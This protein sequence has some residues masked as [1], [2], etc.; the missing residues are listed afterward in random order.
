[1]VNLNALLEQGRA[2]HRTGQLAEAERIYREVLSHAPGEGPVLRDLAWALQKQAKHAAAAEAMQRAV[3]V[4][5]HD[6]LYWCELGTMLRS[7]GKVADAVERFQTSI[8]LNPSLFYSHFNLGNAYRQLEQ[9]Q[10]ARDCYVAAARLA[11]H[12]SDVQISL[13]A[14]QRSLGEFEQARISFQRAMA[15]APRLTEPYVNLGLIEAAL[16]NREEAV[17]WYRSAVENCPQSAPVHN[18]LGLGLRA[19]NSLQPAI[20]EYRRAI[21]I[22]PGLLSA[23]RNLGEALEANGDTPS[24]IQ[25]YQSLLQRANDDGLRIKCALTLP[26][27]LESH[28]QLEQYRQRMVQELDT[29]DPL[30]L[31]VPDPIRSISTISFSLAYH[32]RNERSHQ[33]RVAALVR[34]AAPTVCY[35]APHCETRQIARSHERIKLGFVSYYF[36]DHTIGKLNTGLIEQI[37]RQKFEVIIFRFDH[38]RDGTAQRI[39]R[40]ADRTIHLSANLSHSQSLV[41]KQALDVILYTDIGIES[42]SYYLAHARLAPLQCVTWGHPLTTGIPTLDY[43]ISSKDLETPESDAHYT[44]QLAR[45]PYLANYYFRPEYT[46]STKTREDFGAPANANW[47]GCLQSLFKIHPDDDAVFADILRQDPR[48]CLLLLEGNFPNWTELLRQRLQ[49]SMPDVIDRVRFVPH[50]PPSDFARL[51]SLCDVLLD[52]LHFGGGDTSYQSFAAGTPVVALPGPFLRSRIT[53]ALYCAMGLS[54]CIATD[55]GDFARRAVQLA[56]D[57]DARK[58]VSNKILAAGEAIY[59]NAAGVRAF[60]DFLLDAASRT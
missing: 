15:L 27:I 4:T 23:Y 59:E 49:R 13:G 16:D 37:N 28:E 14:V 34:R 20:D 36:R 29:L 21:A 25:C 30:S 41:A 50:Q 1:V 31:H 26:V 17:R 10:L 18:Q 57:K 47:Y 22:D 8:R 40:A 43:F 55:P 38:S 32:G 12:D 39:E 60:E 9:L 5:P 19:C 2:L 24:A 35:V 3:D 6:A 45:L 48:G 52:P 56:T 53:Y 44:E 7:A 51:L 33:S 54:D 11:P 58:R 42:M 46:P